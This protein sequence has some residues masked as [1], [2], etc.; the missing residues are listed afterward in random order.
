MTS[1]ERR[2]QFLHEKLIG[3]MVRIEPLGDH[4]PEG[5]GG[6]YCPLTEYGVCLFTIDRQ[7]ESIESNSRSV[8]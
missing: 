2:K 8:Q 6:M 5:A 7:G 4:Y 3:K 1:F